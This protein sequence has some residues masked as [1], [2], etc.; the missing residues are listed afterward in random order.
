MSTIRINN[1]NYFGEYIGGPDSKYLAILE[2][3]YMLNRE[4]KEN[5]KK[6]YLKRMK[7]IWKSN[8]NAMNLL[9]TM[10]I[11]ALSRYSDHIHSVHY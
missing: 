10:N 7:L 1:H 2:L 11:R 4:V 9:T 5:I 6:T 8:L 3:D